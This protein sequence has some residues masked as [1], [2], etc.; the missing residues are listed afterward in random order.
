MAATTRSSN[1]VKHPSLEAHTGWAALAIAS[2]G[3]QNE[4]PGVNR[5][6]TG[7][8]GNESAW[9][10]APMRTAGPLNFLDK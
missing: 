8:L 3:L 4:A 1:S 2:L 9:T 6:V 5:T 10:L 7:G